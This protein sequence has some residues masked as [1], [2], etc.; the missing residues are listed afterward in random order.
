MKTTKKTGK[1]AATGGSKNPRI[2]MAGP[3]T[4]KHK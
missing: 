2:P 3:K 1:S 4:G